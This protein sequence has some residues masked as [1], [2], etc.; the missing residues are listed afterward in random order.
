ML[1]L[2]VEVVAGLTVAAPPSPSTGWLRPVLVAG[3][4]VAAAVPALAVGRRLDRSLR[5]FL[6]RLPL[7][8]RWVGIWVCA[9]A[10]AWLA[11]LVLPVLPTALHRDPDGSLATLVAAYE[12]AG[13]RP[14]PPVRAVRTVD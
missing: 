13:R 2:V 14:R 11:L 4:L 6:L 3:G 5:S 10:G 1:L 7:R 8:H 9:L 12:A